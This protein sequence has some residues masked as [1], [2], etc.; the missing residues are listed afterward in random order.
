MEWKWNGMEWKW[1]GQT[2]GRTGMETFT[3]WDQNEQWGDEEIAGLS[4]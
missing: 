2:N 1:N 3:N 4:L